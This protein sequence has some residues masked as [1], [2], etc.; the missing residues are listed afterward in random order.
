LKKTNKRKSRNIASFLLVCL[1]LCLFVVV[2]WQEKQPVKK[3]NVPMP[4]EL[5]ETVA[6]KR[7]ELISL[8][9]DKG[10]NV[11]ITADFRSA[12][13]QDEL[14]AQGRTADGD[15]VTNAK[16][17]E[18]YHNYGLAIDFALMNINGE[19]IWDMEYDGNGNSKDDWS[20]VVEIAKSLGFEWGGDWISFKDYPHFQMDFGL[21][22]EDLQNG[23][24]P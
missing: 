18:S 14:Y 13:E 21:S 24:R 5:N 2:Y 4:T 12:E 19:V 20:E 1:I 15:I 10:I 9:A 11:V 16:G 3:E 17:G 7:D 22:I 23:E 8:A 6:K